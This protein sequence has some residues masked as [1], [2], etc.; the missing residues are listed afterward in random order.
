MSN[1][2]DKDPFPA[3]GETPPHEGGN[4]EG[5]TLDSGRPAV[6]AAP[7]KMMFVLL[8]ALLFVGIV[9][10]SLFFTS[11]PAPV[12]VK[13]EKEHVQTSNNTPDNLIPQRD[14]PQPPPEIVNI[15]PPPPPPAPTLPQ[16]APPVPKVTAQGPNQEA[17]NKRVHSQMLV[18][19]GHGNG[20]LGVS[21]RA[22][23]GAATGDPN[24]AFA[25]AV[26]DSEAETVEAKKMGNLNGIIGQGKLI[27]AVL[28][29]AIDSDLPGT[30]R[31]VV[32]HDIYAEAGRAILIP[33]G[34]RLIGTYNAA[35][36]RGQNRVFI[37]WMRVMRPDGIDVMINSPGVDMLGRAGM[38]GDVDNKYFEAYST[39]IL[40]SAMDIGVAGIGQA[41][42][43]NNQ[44]TTT[45]S[46]SGGTTTA[47]SPEGTA[48]QQAVSN[49]GDVSKSIVASTL[50]AQPTIYVD[51]GTPIIVFVNK[52]LIFPPSVV[53]SIHNE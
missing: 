14:M 34:S 26:E 40:S 21:K 3:T 22:R 5:L 27:H 36:K 38:G 48:M 31:A 15:P 4:G 42:F 51:Q 24:L 17:L 45:T 53:S 44:Q 43:G 11:A 20:P 16:V 2:N 13:K 29:S 39:A 50:N 18:M 25:A 12:H 37:I 46:N 7:G 8:G 28:E 10:K 47:S 33:K 6:A 49:I 52:D 19:A 30:I 32:S 9:V 23:A 35:V 1:G 41:L